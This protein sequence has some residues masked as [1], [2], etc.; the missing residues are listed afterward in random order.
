MAKGIR[1]KDT[2]AMSGSAL[3]ILL[4]E[5]KEDWEKKAK[6]AHDAATEMDIR[7]TGKDGIAALRGIR[8]MPYLG[9]IYPMFTDDELRSIGIDPATCAFYKGKL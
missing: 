1:Y 6:A 5:K 3:H 7:L 8:E 4:T 2:M 9:P